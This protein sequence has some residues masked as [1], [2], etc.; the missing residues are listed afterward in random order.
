MKAAVL[1]R[2]HMQSCVQLWCHVLPLLTAQP[3]ST[4][5][6]ACQIAHLHSHAKPVIT[7]FIIIPLLLI[8]HHPA[9]LECNH[10][11]CAL[12]IHVGVNNEL[13]DRQLPSPCN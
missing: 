7:S 2:T 4:H 3:A 11:H 5:A 13:A 1:T 6:E 12:H 8:R 10:V 9:L